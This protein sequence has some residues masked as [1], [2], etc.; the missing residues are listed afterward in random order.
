MTVLDIN[1]A[2]VYSGEIT[3]SVPEDVAIGYTVGQV[4]VTDPDHD[5]KL[6]YT[7]TRTGGKFQVINVTCTNKVYFTM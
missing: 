4:V 1:E 3:F 2:P 5:E 6:T 7:L